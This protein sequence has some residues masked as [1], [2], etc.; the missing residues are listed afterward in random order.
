M[1]TFLTRTGGLLLLILSGS[2]LLNQAVNAQ[3]RL[4][5]LEL[6]DQLLYEPGSDTPYTGPVTDNG[7]TVGQVEAGKR[8][9]E[10]VWYSPQ[11]DREFMVVYEDGVRIRSMGWHP[12]GQRE[13][14]WTFKN[15]QPDGTMRSWDRHGTLRQERVMVAGLLQGS[16]QIWDHHGN[17]LYS[18]TYTNGELDGPATWW[19]TNGNKRWETH[20]AAGEKTGTW[21]QRDTDGSLRMRTEWENGILVSR[22][23]PHANH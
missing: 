1:T 6:R 4:N 7:T 12:N 20:Y 13:T 2:L 3:I 23:N 19:H 10:W 16:Y 18:A 11:G 21:E 8:M 9:G 17:L 5:D 14:E 22:H 15:G